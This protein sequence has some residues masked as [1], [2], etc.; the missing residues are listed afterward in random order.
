MK[1]KMNSSPG[2]RAPSAVPKLELSQEIARS[3][4]SSDRCNIRT[5]V[6][7]RQ[8]LRGKSKPSLLRHS[9]KRLILR[10]PQS[11]HVNTHALT[12][13]P[14]SAEDTDVA[15]IDKAAATSA[16]CNQKKTINKRTAFSE[17][18]TKDNKSHPFYASYRSMW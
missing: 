14:A 17:T 2:L 12:A 8:P 9:T 7:E 13:A 5:Y 11:L 18:P 6:C 16:P 15:Q 10:T 1:Y 3:A 4:V